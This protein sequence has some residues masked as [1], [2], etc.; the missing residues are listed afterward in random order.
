MVTRTVVLICA[1]AAGCPAAPGADMDANPEARALLRQFRE[2]AVA[3]T[4]LEDRFEPG[5][6]GTAVGPV[7]TAPGRNAEANP[8]DRAAAFPE[9]REE[10][11]YLYY[12]PH[13]PLRGRFELDFRV[14]NFPGDHNFMT[15]FSIGTGG[16]TCLTVRYYSDHTVHA[17]SLTKREY[18]KLESD[19]LAPGVWHRLEY[20]YAPEGC[21]LLIDGAIHDYSAEYSSPYATE[22]AN[23]FYLGD[24]P[25][26]DPAGRKAVW[27]PL[28]N[29]VGLLDNLTLTRVQ[30]GGAR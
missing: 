14:D 27:Y 2:M 12:S 15:L 19:P 25:W 17:T 22:I 13:I 20:W 26:W 29:F 1:L 24:Q 11:Q 3:G 4:S 7:G 10:A 8:A 30:K 6:K 9:N 21:M 28:D 23:A 18:L 5:P 16:N